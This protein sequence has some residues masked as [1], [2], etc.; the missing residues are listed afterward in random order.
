MAVLVIAALGDAAKL[1]GQPAGGVTAG[2]AGREARSHAA[3]LQSR[4]VPW[5]SLAQHAA[6][7]RPRSPVRIRSG[8]PNLNLPTAWRG[9]RARLKAT[10]SK[11]VIGATLSW[12]R[13]PPSPP[14]PE[15]GLAAHQAARLRAASS[16]VLSEASYWMAS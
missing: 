15:L 10:V 16:E 6:L 12:V 1:N 7:S 4:L 9:G 5:C 2:E 11:T 14:P 3:K 8:P 13:I